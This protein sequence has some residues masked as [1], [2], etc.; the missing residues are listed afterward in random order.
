MWYFTIKQASIQTKPYQ[1]L[2]KLAEGTEVEIFSEPYENYC[3]FEVEK[4]RYQNMMDYLDREGI[5][6]SLSATRPSRDELLE[7]MK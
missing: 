1:H 4:D 6:Y 2:Q 7:S 5:A 3:V